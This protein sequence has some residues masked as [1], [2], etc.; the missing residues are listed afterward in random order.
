MAAVA[1]AENLSQPERHTPSPAPALSLAPAP[2][3]HTTEHFAFEKLKELRRLL[4]RDDPQ[5][6]P[7]GFH[8]AHHG[9]YEAPNGGLEGL[10]IKGLELANR[11][12]TASIAHHAWH[13][14]DAAG[15]L[16][17]AG[18][19]DTK[20]LLERYPID[21]TLPSLAEE[22]TYLRRLIDF[23]PHDSALE[24]RSQSLVLT[25]DTL[26]SALHN[27]RSQRSPLD[28][29]HALGYLRAEIDHGGE[30][31]GAAGNTD[32]QNRLQY[33][34]TRFDE[35][36][37]PAGFL[38]TMFGRLCLHDLRGESAEEKI[39]DVLLDL[40]LYTEC[41][42][43]R[44]EMLDQAL[45][46]RESRTY[47]IFPRTFNLQGFCAARG[48][49]QQNDGQFLKDFPDQ[50]L[51]QLKAQGL[52][53]LYLL[54]INPLGEQHAL[55][56]GGGSPFCIKDM[57][58]I[59]P[60]HGTFADFQN[61]IARTHRRGMTIMTDL[62][63]NHT[64]FD[65]TLLAEDP[66]YYVHLKADLRENIPETERHLESSYP[67]PPEGYRFYF[68][69]ASQ[70]GFYIRMA[71]YF[72]MQENRRVFYEDVAQLDLFNPATR[73]RYIT[74]VLDFL[75]RS[76][77]N[78]SGRGIDA[79]RVDMAHHLLTRKYAV[80]G[81]GRDCPN[82][83]P[84]PEQEFLA[85]MVSAIKERFPHVAIVAECHEHLL[86]LRQAGFDAFLNK[87]DMPGGTN[88]HR[89]AVRG[90]YD[91]LASRDSTKVAQAIEN[92]IIHEQGFGDALRVRYPADHDLPP[93]I[94]ELT[95]PSPWYTPEHDRAPRPELLKPLTALTMLSGSGPVLLV[96]GHETVSH[97]VPE[98]MK[99]SDGTRR[100]PSF[101]QPTVID[102]SSHEGESQEMYRQIFSD[103]TALLN[104]I[105][106]FRV[107]ETLLDESVVGFIVRPRTVQ[108]Q[109]GALVVA[110]LGSTPRT[111]QVPV[112]HWNKDGMRIE[113]SISIEVGAADYAV[114]RFGTPA[115]A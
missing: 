91:A 53:Q 69:Q 88:E 106:Q 105:G 75:E 47:N 99:V 114:S 61:L 25:L 93:L 22:L 109:Q 29:I 41:L 70:S 13:M 113:T 19:S 36:P 24:T 76:A 102:W 87:N 7:F 94:K 84:E 90:W 55:G 14:A 89:M 31:F 62:V 30:P 56:T 100:Y 3:T 107:S 57:H 32:I 12:G 101:E 72:E 6:A 92:L 110:N 28:L 23:A 85:E 59:D 8:V 45:W 79:L 97:T 112:E 20:Y 96:A 10:I 49:P 26:I 66:S 95:E 68:H 103:F 15:N 77:Q 80:Y 40:Q 51:D 33:I 71:G 54:G 67:P 9:Y 38:S 27:E 82:Q 108:T 44:V 64:S 17:L 21:A 16:L 65:S 83:H 111:V 81:R 104:D 74:G 43:G 58:A 18:V 115:T 86:E 37:D 4:S 5:A 78:E 48:I 34:S 35:L 60:Q 1:H 42:Q 73:T 50:A 11:F 46:F 39:S 2:S 52:N 98:R 63:A